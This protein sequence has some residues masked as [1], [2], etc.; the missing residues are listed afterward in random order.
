MFHSR[1]LS[2]WPGPLHCTGPVLPRPGLLSL[3]LP[4]SRDALP[5]GICR[6]VTRVPLDW[7]TASA[8][9]RRNFRSQRRRPNAQ[10]RDWFSPR[11]FS[12]LG[13]WAAP[14]DCGEPS[15]G[16]EEFGWGFHPVISSWGR[17]RELSRALRGG[18]QGT[19]DTCITM[20]RRHRGMVCDI[21]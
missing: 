6:G 11:G 14:G 1:Y 13:R 19:L 18:G 10:C 17:E 20:F 5:K 12:R 3:H 21:L 16:Q 9:S 4:Q 2:A 7:A 15:P 8:I